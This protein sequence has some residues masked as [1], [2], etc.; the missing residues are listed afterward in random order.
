MSTSSN[1]AA[2]A[3]ARNGNMRA[4]FRRTDPRRHD[5]LSLRG[6]RAFRRAAPSLKVTTTA[7]GVSDTTASAWQTSGEG[8]PATAFYCLIDRLAQD[9]RAHPGALV[10]EAKITLLES[11]MPLSDHDLAK[12]FW[13]LTL[14]EAAVEGRLNET[15]QMFA[16]NGDLSA[17]AAAAR[18]VADNATELAV[19]AGEL[20]KRGIDLRAGFAGR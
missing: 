7:L 18:A 5:E 11:V 19:V 9:P 6:A 8:S 16:A 10:T 1:S 4:K 20:V 3:P 13:Q 15:Q 17:L 2:P 14:D 12:R